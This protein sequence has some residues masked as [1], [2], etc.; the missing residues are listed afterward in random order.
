MV[1]TVAYVSGAAGFSPRGRRALPR[2]PRFGRH[3][4]EGPQLDEAQPELS[5]LRVERGG[6][7]Q[8][9]PQALFS[10]HTAQWGNFRGWQQ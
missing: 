9:K 6:R 5:E 2:L 10:R 7:N 8:S 1:V 4:G 3:L